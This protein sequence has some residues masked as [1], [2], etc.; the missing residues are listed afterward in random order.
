MNR[1]LALPLLLLAILSCGKQGQAPPSSPGS[2]AQTP[3]PPT[4]RPI[5]KRVTLQ[6][7]AETWR[8]DQRP[9]DMGAD[10]SARLKRI[11]VDV[12]ADG[13]SAPDGVLL[14]ELAE[15]PYGDYMFAG[16]GTML[17]F[18]MSVLDGHKAK[19]LGQLKGLADTPFSVSGGKTLYDAALEELRKDQLYAN[20][21]HV[22]AAALGM[23]SAFRPALQ[24]AIW[25]RVS[26]QVLPILKRANFHPSNPEEEA[27]L[28]IAEGHYEASVKYGK[29]AV[30]PL[31]VLLQG[32]Y[33]AD[34]ST[35][36]AKALGDIGD[37]SAAKALLN[38]L[39]D[40][41]HSANS[42]EDKRMVI[43]FIEALGKMGDAF[44]LSDLDQIAHDKDSSFAPHAARAG[45]QIRERNGGSR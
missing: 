2:R 43:A 9:F 41:V 1:L 45:A 44:A 37:P 40:S 3:R 31:L 39:R 18:T 17:T 19:S 32:W 7:R 24:A 38:R 23:S 12:I 28:A 34:V 30:P 25:P 26:P 20:A 22:V 35:K 13:A 16:K 6:V 36:V 4:P 42:E 11:G 14:I 5:E 21:H 10:M 8:K 29:A 33:W 27:L 15:T